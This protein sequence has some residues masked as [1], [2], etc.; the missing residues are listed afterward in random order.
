MNGLVSPGF[1]PDTTLRQMRQLNR[2]RFHYTEQLSQV[3]NRILKVLETANLKF[4][5]VLSNVNTKSAR[6]II[7]ALSAGV[8]DIKLLQSYCLRKAAKKAPL[9]PEAL[10]GTL[11]DNDGKMLRLY[12]SD[13]DY[14]DN[15]IIELEQS[16]NAILEQGY[17]PVIGL[18][19]Q[20]PGIGEQSAR[21]IV[22]EVGNNLQAFPSAD[23]FTSW[24]GLAPGNRQSANKWFAQHTTKG[25]KYFRATLIQVAWA[26]VRTKD[27][28][29]Q[30][31]FQYL[32]NRLPAKKAIVAIA[33]KMAKLIYRV[34]T[35]QY[36]YE[37]KGAAYFINQR[38]KFHASKIVAG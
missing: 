18:L 29:W 19:Q 12:L 21:T 30:A 24:A 35:E 4:R 26:A 23:H 25:N 15:Q 27:G 14:F 3:K 7:K 13:W 33:G 31:Q 16:M 6:L 28:Y 9:L 36:Q 5:S 8:T 22:A 32:K 2:Q 17:N 11:T 20:V 1:I 34:I 37:E 10:D 38:G